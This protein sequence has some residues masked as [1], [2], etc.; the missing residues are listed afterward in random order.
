MREYDKDI[1]R[2]CL[3]ILNPINPILE[4]HKNDRIKN[5]ELCYNPY[6]LHLNN[7]NT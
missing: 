4:P 5:L 1:Q 6:I 3:N 2:I 7:L